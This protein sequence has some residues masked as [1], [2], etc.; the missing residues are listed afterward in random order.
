MLDKQ[1]MYDM[2]TKFVIQYLVKD[3]KMNIG[4]AH[5]LWANSKT[6]KFIQD[7]KSDYSCVAPTRC[8]DELMMELS[9]DPH[10]LKG[11]FE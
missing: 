6:K 7:N 1:A 3:K 5:K 2:Q 10:W 9:Q 8:Y 11:Q 4:D